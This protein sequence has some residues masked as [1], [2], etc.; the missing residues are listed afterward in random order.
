MLGNRLL[1]ILHTVGYGHHSLMWTG[2]MYDIRMGGSAFDNKLKCAFSTSLLIYD[3]GHILHSFTSH[4][5]ISF[6]LDP[7]YVIRLKST[8][9]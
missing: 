4:Y 7:G 1:S 2:N 5:G 8:C 3:K 6:Q 9:A